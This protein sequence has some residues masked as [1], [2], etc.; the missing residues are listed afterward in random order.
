MD[1]FDKVYMEMYDAN[2]FIEDVYGEMGDVVSQSV[3]G[4]AA[5]LSMPNIIRPLI[6][7]QIEDYDFEITCMNLFL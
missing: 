1:L 6:Y 3:L 4:Q 7:Q 5:A 2:T